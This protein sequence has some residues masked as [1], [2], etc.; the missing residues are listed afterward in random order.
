LPERIILIGMMGA[1][2]TT[3]G[4]LLAR[5][6]G[7]SY[8]DSDAQIVD[9]TGRTVREIFEADGEAAFRRLESEVLRDAFDGD[10]RVVVSVAG[11]AVLDLENR[12][13][14]REGGA[15]VWLRAPVEVLASRVTSGDHRPLLQDD[16]EETLRRLYAE[17]EPLYQELADVTVDVSSATPDAIVDQI[18]AALA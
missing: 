12:R 9:R 17:R 13:M 18:E 6:R 2:K 10:G 8:V 7:W 11:G 5:R 3:V 1:G 16:P 14:I 15:I 4:R